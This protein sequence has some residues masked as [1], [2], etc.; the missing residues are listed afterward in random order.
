MHKRSF[1][2]A[3]ICTLLPLIASCY[4]MPPVKPEKVRID[5]I[6]TVD[7]P[8]DKVFDAFV[9]Y[10]KDKNLTLTTSDD[11]TGKIITDDIMITDTNMYEFYY[12]YV[13]ENKV[14][15]YYGMHK[16]QFNRM[17][18]DGE[19]VR[20]E[21]CDC[22]NAMHLSLSKSKNKYNEWQN[23]FYH[24]EIDIRKESSTTTS[25]RVQTKFWTELF[26]FG[27]IYFSYEGIWDCYSTGEYE[28]KLIEEVKTK[29]LK[30]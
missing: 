2:L 19:K 10:F 21:Y 24:Y 11:F 16:G 28:K 20:L 29:Y 13:K 25:F 7:V 17:L 3:L 26:T 14:E 4:T 15:P 27:G 1:L 23:L 5:N 12:D 18:L 8:S 22:G 30:K 6:I 9:D